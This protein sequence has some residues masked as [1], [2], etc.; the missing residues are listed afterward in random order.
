MECRNCG[1]QS[2]DEKEF[3]H[4]LTVIVYGVGFYYCQWECLVNAINEEVQN[5]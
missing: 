5:P 1:F 2:D 3:S 4:K